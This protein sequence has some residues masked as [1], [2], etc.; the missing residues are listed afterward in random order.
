MFSSLALES[1]GAGVA[2]AALGPPKAKKRAPTVATSGLRR[3]PFESFRLPDE[4][5]NT[6]DMKMRLGKTDHERLVALLEPLVDCFTGARLAHL[7]EAKAEGVFDLLDGLGWGEPDAD[8]DVATLSLLVQSEIESLDEWIADLADCLCRRPGCA[9]ESAIG[10]ET[11]ADLRRRINGALNQR[12]AAAQLLE[13][14]RCAH[15]DAVGRR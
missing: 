13:A 12:H 1:P 8:V 5:S 4:R 11:T 3:R 7:R 10:V 15:F 14:V 6:A 2:S 9:D